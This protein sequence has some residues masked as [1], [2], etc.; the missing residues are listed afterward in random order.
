M[1]IGVARLVR[2]LKKQGSS[3]TQYYPFFALKY[4]QRLCLCLIHINSLI[5]QQTK[6]TSHGHFCELLAWQSEREITKN[7]L[8]NV[9]GSE[10]STFY[11]VLIARCILSLWSF[12]G[13]EMINSLWIAEIFG[14][15]VNFQGFRDKKT[16]SV[17]WKTWKSSLIW[18]DF[19]SAAGFFWKRLIDFR[20][21][22]H[23]ILK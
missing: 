3:E 4:F 19:L 13:D 16:I 20:P 22:L 14:V 11:E 7:L 8:I 18:Y 12:E 9:R 15:I 1:H 6:K 21:S 2:K 5:R 10:A 17:V 23:Q